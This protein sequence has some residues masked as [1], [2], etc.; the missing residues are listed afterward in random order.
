MAPAF[1]T[2]AVN[3]GE[4]VNLYDETG[5]PALDY[6]LEQRLK[7]LDPRLRVTFSSF[8]LDPHSGRPIRDQLTG[9]PI[10]EPAQ[11]LWLKDSDGWRHVDTF[12]ME[13]GGFSHLNVRYLELNEQIRNAEK[14]ERIYRLI[15][16]RKRTQQ[17]L[18]KRSN[19]DRRN[20]RTKANSKRIGDLVFHGK[21]GQRQAK[22][23]SYAGQTKHSTP[24]NVLSDPRE[25]GWEL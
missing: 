20:E 7:R 9:E 24:G 11:H 12:L 15:E 25:D 10:K 17:Q 16:D 8:A 5:G 6:G 23:S 19:R 22:V 21:S 2:A 3:M 13:K 18:A 14:P 1:F 4:T